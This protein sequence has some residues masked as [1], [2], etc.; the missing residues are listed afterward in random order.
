MPLTCFYQ[1]LDKGGFQRSTIVGNRFPDDSKRL[2]VL[3]LFICAKGK[4]MR[5]RHLTDRNLRTARLPLSQ[6][7]MNRNTYN[8]YGKLRRILHQKRFE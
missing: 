1:N 6:E 2:K 5:K 3:Y 8:I 7:Q 4:C